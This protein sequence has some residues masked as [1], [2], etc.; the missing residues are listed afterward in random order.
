MSFGYGKLFASMFDGTLATRGPWQALVTFQQLLIL[1]DQEGN[2]DMTPE[3]IARRTTVPLEI[4]ETGIRALEQPDPESRLPH[5]EGRRIV[6]LSEHRSWGWHIV[7][8]A[9]YRNV[10]TPQDRR[11][12]MR[13]YQ[14]NRRSNGVNSDVNSH[15]NNVNSVNSGKRVSP[16]RSRSISSKPMATIPVAEGFDRIWAAYPRK[17]KKVDAVKAFAKLNPTAELV[18]TIVADVTRRCASPDWMKDGGSFIPYP[19]S[20]LNGRRWE[21]EP[22]SRGS[23]A[24]AAPGF[25]F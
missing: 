1:C 5:E 23:G 18:D 13:E 25:Q 7:N 2:V 3:A 9:H 21:D 17:V 16:Y 14:R 20:Y 11:E 8:H 4:I 15:V 12:Y 10:R 22:S 24:A 6:R 19:A